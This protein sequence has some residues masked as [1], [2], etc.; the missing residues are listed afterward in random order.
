MLEKRS[1]KGKNINVTSST[2]KVCLGFRKFEYCFIVLLLSK[3]CNK[4][5]L[6]Q[7]DPYWVIAITNIFKVLIV[8]NSSVNFFIYRLKYFMAK[9]QCG[10]VCRGRSKKKDD[11][12]I[13]L[14]TARSKRSTFATRTTPQT[15]FDK[16]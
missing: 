7:D 2:Y 10:N 8:L 12:R 16:S 11:T 3:N 4:F 15:T 5:R 6:L 9:G 13:E 14:Q 1:A